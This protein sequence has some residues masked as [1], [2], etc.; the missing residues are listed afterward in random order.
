METSYKIFAERLQNTS[1]SLYER[2][3][4][5]AALCELY[6]LIQIKTQDLQRRLKHFKL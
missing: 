1:L 4:I 5:K 3:V 6:F 2:A